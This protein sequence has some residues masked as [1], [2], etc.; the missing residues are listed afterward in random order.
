MRM[1]RRMIGRGALAL[2]ATLATLWA[3]AAGAVNVNFVSGATGSDIDMM[4]ELVK[5]WEAETGNTVTIVPMPSSTTDQF[6]QYRLWLAAGN[7]DIDV[8]MTDVIWAPQLSDSF[9]DLTE[10]AADVIPDHFPSIIESQTVDGKLVAL[11]LFTDA[12]ALYYR[13][14][15]LEKHGAAVPTTWEELTATAQKIMDAE[16]AEGAGRPLGLRLA[17]QRLRGPDL[18]RAGVDQVERRRPDHRARRHDLGQQRERGEGA[19]DGQGLGRH[20]LAARACSPTWRRSRAASG[21][22]ATPSS[23]A[24]GPTPTRSATATTARSRASSTWRRCRRAAATTRRRRRSA[25]GTSRC[26]RYSP[27]PEAAISL[28]DVHGLDRVPEAA[29]AART[30]TC[31][32][33][34]RSTTTRRS[35]RRSR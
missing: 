32:R 16:R 5:P 22:P 9:L 31:R 26:R 1:E 30:R 27:N 11:P 4:R 28:V 29:G 34:S 35:P 25:A 6:A 23:C 18:Q 13:K 15:L 10:A 3:S 17:G 24:T 21:R 2:G 14:D 7:A 19:R 12:P 8:Y 33:S 20:H